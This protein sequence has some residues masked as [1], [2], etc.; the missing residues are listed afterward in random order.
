MPPRI[1]TLTL[2]CALLAGCGD[3]DDTAPPSE[4]DTE[5]TA[6]HDTDADADA[7]ADTDTD[8]D[9]DADADS[10][11]DADGVYVLGSDGTLLPGWEG[12]AKAGM[13]VTGLGD[14]DGDGYDDIIVSMNDAIGVCS[15]P[16]AAAI[17]LRGGPSWPSDAERALADADATLCL[18]SEGDLATAIVGRVGDLDAD[19]LPDLVVG[20]PE[21]GAAGEHSGAVFV[22]S[23]A[24]LP[25]GGA[26]TQL[27]TIGRRI[28][29]VAMADQAGV[30]FEGAGDVDGD[31]YDDLLVGAAFGDDGDQNGGAAYLL[32]G[33][34]THQS[35]LSEA[36]WVWYGEAQDDYFGGNL[37]TA[38]DTDG[39]GLADMLFG[40]VH[41]TDGTQRIGAAYLVL[42]SGAGWA[43]QQSTDADVEIRGAGNVCYLGAAVDGGQDVNGDGYDDVLIGAPNA[44]PSTGISGVVLLFQG[45][46]EGASAMEDAEATFW[47]SDESYLGGRVAMVGDVDADG[48]ADLLLGDSTQDTATGHAWLWLDTASGSVDLAE[49]AAHLSG[50]TEGEYT[51][52]ATAGAGD[53]NADGYD[54]LLLG[55]YHWDLGVYQPGAAWLLTG[56]A[57]W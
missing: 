5:R 37:S 57:D 32:R 15:Y 22:V 48:L 45:P 41:V 16:H 51:A 10:D 9:T 23:A 11:A 40:A 43:S 26:V 49:A 50:S 42:G 6:P 3:K 30:A 53:V 36:D 13:G 19:G 29:G 2:L 47:S 1:T 8:T 20:D 12:G 17:L 14:V 25:L 28:A 55:A 18:G 4:G 39:D 34:V 46:L 44:T 7:D 52:Y 54:D 33:P 21:N 24:D 31:G 56:R 27:D 38:G 35:S